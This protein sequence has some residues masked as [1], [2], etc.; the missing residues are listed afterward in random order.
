MHVPLVLA[1]VGPTAAGKTPLAVQL[2][3]L[4]SG[5]VLSADSRQIY[6][7]LD[8]GTAKPTPSERQGVPHHFLDILDPNA[9]YNAGQFG[10][11]ARDCAAEVAVKGNLP[12]L[13]G[14]SG[15]YV[16]SF[17]DG[18]FTGPGKDMDLRS[19]LQELLDEEGEAALYAEL[20]KVDPV[21]AA[22]LESGKPRRAM[23][24]LEV[25]YTTGKPI[26]EHHKEQIPQGVVKVL[27]IGLQIEREE[28]HRRIDDRAAHM[29]ERGLVDEVRSLL[30]RGYDRSLNALNTV[31][32][33]EVLDLLD[34]KSGEKEMLESIRRN[35][36]RFAKRQMTWFRADKRIHWITAGKQTALKKLAGEIVEHMKQEEGVH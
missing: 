36:R 10:I 14:G 29:I 19:R 25:F 5:E 31:G 1:I 35:T 27:Q 2:A 15:L 34:G 23:R 32:Y 20:R 30:A 18:L 26:S 3:Q 33:K 21:A 28:L 22:K 9:P 11:E 12:I 16:R 24:A 17:V 13:V 8:I 4:L 7:Y 6:R